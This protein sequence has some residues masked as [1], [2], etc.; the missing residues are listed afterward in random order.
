MKSVIFM[1]EGLDAPNISNNGYILHKL[2]I[3]QN[4]FFI[5]SFENI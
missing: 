1:F 3:F 2:F 4:E 5:F